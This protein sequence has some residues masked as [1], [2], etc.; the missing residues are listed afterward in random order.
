MRSKWHLRC[1]SNQRRGTKIRANNSCSLFYMPYFKY[2]ARFISIHLHNRL[3]NLSVN[4]LYVRIVGIINARIS[5]YTFILYVRARVGPNNTK[6]SEREIA[7]VRAAN[8]RICCKVLWNKQTVVVCPVPLNPKT[9]GNR[10]QSRAKSD[11]LRRNTQ[12]QYIKWKVKIM[13]NYDECFAMIISLCLMYL[14]WC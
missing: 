10:V 7:N 13:A 6:A 12:F 14:S 9:A 5:T 2:G 3:L 4:V 11:T 1:N 8:K